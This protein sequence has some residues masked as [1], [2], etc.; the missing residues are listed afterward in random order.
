MNIFKK[1]LRAI[2]CQQKIDQ[3]E[4]AEVIGVSNRAVSA[5][6]T[7]KSYPSMENFI[8]IVEFLDVSADY[9]LGFSDDIKGTR[10]EEDDILAI[11]KSYEKMS[12]RER[13]IFK[14]FAINLTTEEIKERGVD[15][16]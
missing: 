12:A 3:R 15:T 5:Y 10:P 14:D 11:K 1:R 6:V 8:K 2:L 4:L 13:R 7:G 16:A 9:L